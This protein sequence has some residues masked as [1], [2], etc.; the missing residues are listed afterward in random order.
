MDFDPVNR[1]VP[2]PRYELESGSEDEFKAGLEVA[3]SKTQEP[4]R[5]VNTDGS[6]ANGVLEHGTQMVIL[7]GNAGAAFLSSLQSTVPTQGL[8]LQT[9]TE[10]HAAIAAIDSASGTKLTVALVAPP[11]QL[12]SSRFH[13]IARALL[14]AIH[15]SSLVIVDSYSPQEQLYRDPYS[16]DAEE[17]AGADT[18]VRYLA[19]PSYVAKHKVDAKKM[20]PLR[21]PEAA[22]GLGAAFLATVSLRDLAVLST[23]LD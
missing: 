23:R 21:S 1:D 18:A 8:S 20:A 5:I 13:E 12:R 15:P 10:Q 3:A 7:V 19:T 22:T 14:E 17:S 4:F 11:P 9:G 2:A 6:D 16:E